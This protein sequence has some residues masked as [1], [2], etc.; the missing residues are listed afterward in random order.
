VS[1]AELGVKRRCLSCN[2]AFFDL[3]RAPPVCPSCLTVFE[4]I[5]IAHSRPRR[6]TFDSDRAPR[7]EV[8]VNDLDAD[9]VSSEDAPPQSDEQDLGE[10]EENVLLPLDDEDEE[11]QPDPDM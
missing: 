7:Q 9:P 10:E 8:V 5:E 6:P 11:I 3:N 2:K 1:R 4:V